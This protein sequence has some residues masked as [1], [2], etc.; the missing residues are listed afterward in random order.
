MVSLSSLAGAGWQFFDDSGDPLSGGKIYTYAAGT[1][2]PLTTYTNSTGVT[3]N[4]NPVVLDSAGRVPEEIWLDSTLNYKFVLQSFTGTLIWTKDNVTGILASQSLTAAIV[5]YN[6]PFTGAVDTNVAAKLSQYISVAD[7]GA[8]GDGVTDDS[9]AVQKAFDYIAPLGGT[10]FFPRGRYLFGSQVVIDRRYASYAGGTFVGERNLIV[11]G[12][13]AEI[14]TSGAI[15]AF[16]VRGGWLPNH[17]CRIEGFTVYHRGNTTAVGGIRLIGAGAVTCYEISVVVSSSLPVGYAAFSC[18]NLDPA[19]DDTGCFWNYF[20]NCAIR[21][22]AGA[23]GNCT[24]GLKLMGTANATTVRNIKFSGSNTHIIIMAS[25]G[26]TSSPNSVNIDGNFFEGPNTST[27]IS[28]VS[29]STPYHITGTRITN[30]RFE[31]INTAVS[32]TGSGS[33]VQTPT[34]MCG[35]YGDTSVTN[36]VVNPSNIPIVMLDAGLVSAPMGPM[37]THNQEGLIVKNNNAAFDTLTLRTPNLNCGVKITDINGTSLG[38]WRFRSFG[39]NIGTA[40]GGT[41]SPLRPF[42]IAACYGIST[43]ETLAHNLAGVA[44]FSAAAT[45]TV[46]FLIPETNTNYSVFLENT[47]N[48]TLWV[49]NKTTA[50]FTINA[51]AA[52]SASVSWLLIRTGV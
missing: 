3:P 11:S 2:T 5:G 50:G 40:I 37:I 36:Y 35:N 12:Y 7:F 44:S 9:A 16:D 4:A 13:G 10:L 27:A 46:T 15:T 25:P 6:P 29:S 49:T 33:D 39:G 45:T 34:Y 47:G 23:E 14:R 30:N 17:N 21:P 52:S 24:Y 26:Y 31:A 28:L 1:T 41:N 48:R 42:G 32:L 22:W 38:A 20:D 18:E 8:V 43:T 51:S 19:N